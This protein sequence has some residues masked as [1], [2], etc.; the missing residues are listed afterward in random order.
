MGLVTI[1]SNTLIGS[2]VTIETIVHSAHYLDRRR[3]DSTTLPVVIESDC[4]LAH[5]V[6]V[7][8]GVTIGKGAIVGAGAVVTR[9]IPAFTMAGG[10]PATVKRRLK[11]Q[12]ECDRR[13]AGTK[14][15]EE[16]DIGSSWTQRNI[17]YHIA[18]ASA[19]RI[20]DHRPYDWIDR[21]RLGHMKPWVQKLRGKTWSSAEMRDVMQGF[22][23][24]PGTPCCFSA[25]ELL[26]AH[27]NAVVVL[28]I[29]PLEP[30]YR[31]MQKTMWKVQQHWSTYRI[32]ELLN[33]QIIA[34]H[35]RFEWE[36]FCGHD[37]SEDTVRQAFD[38][39]YAHVRRVV[40]KEKLLEYDLGSGWESLY[41]FLEK[42]VPKESYLRTN[43]MDEW[44]KKAH[45]AYWYYVKITVWK[46]FKVVVAPLAVLTAGAIL[47]L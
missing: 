15:D 1:G 29:R 32:L 23:E 46:A 21:Y 37:Y 22:Q 27:S 44:M 41:K 20:L 47:I 35:C 5:N 36:I 17:A 26:E 10:V 30:R 42:E 43:N 39:H 28:T 33:P 7:L 18:I 38:D 2:H 31:F 4:W 14:E 13:I 9:D 45:M 34:K 16:E 6:T 25:E 24:V 12:E 11:D 3:P 40:P 19:L 8:P